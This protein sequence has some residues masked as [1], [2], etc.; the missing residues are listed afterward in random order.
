MDNFISD[1]N[2]K[3]EKEKV[4]HHSKGAEITKEY[5]KYLSN[6]IDLF[7]EQIERQQVGVDRGIQNY[8]KSVNDKKTVASSLAYGS[9]IINNISCEYIDNLKNILGKNYVKN[10]EIKNFLEHKL[11]YKKYNKEGEEKNMSSKL[12]TLDQ[13]AQ[14]TLMT[15][16]NHVDLK[17]KQE[18]GKN[19]EVNLR[20]VANTVVRE[21]ITAMKHK[22]LMLQFGG[23]YR[24]IEETR[25]TNN[26]WKKAQMYNSGIARLLESGAEI[27]IPF[28]ESKLQLKIGHLL[29]GILESMDIIKR[30][31]YNS[32]KKNKKDYITFTDKIKEEI[33]DINKEFRE[34]RPKTVP[35]IIKPKPWVNLVGGGFLNGEVYQEIGYNF[36]Y[37]QNKLVRTNNKEQ[38]KLLYKNNIDEVYD[39]LNSI[40][41]TAWKIN[42]NV[43]NVIKNLWENGVELDKMPNSKKLIPEPMPWNAE[44]DKEILKKW[45]R[46]TTLIHDKNAETISERMTFQF[47][48]E[49]AKECLDYNEIYF[50]YN[51][52]Y[53]GRVYP[54]NPLLNPQG[55]DPVKGMLTF[56]KGLPLGKEKIMLDTDGNVILDE[57]GKPIMKNGL[58]W[59]M[60]HTAN[61]YGNDKGQFDNR[62]K[63]VQD[64][65]ELL[66]SIAENPIDN[67]KLWK[68]TD[69][70]FQF[71]AACIEI[72]GAY[73][74]EN[75]E[76]FI[77][78]LPIAIDGSCSGIQHLSA[79]GRDEVGGAG[80][81]LLDS[82]E[83]NDIYLDVANELI[84][85]LR[86]E[87][88]TQSL[89]WLNSDAINRKLTKRPVMTTPYGVGGFGMFDQVK[90]VLDKLILSEEL[91]DNKNIVYIRDKIDEAIKNI[92]IGARIIMKY[93]QDISR[94]YM[95][96][97]NNTMKWTTPLNFVVVQDY[98]KNELEKRVTTLFGSMKI[99]SRFNTI[100]ENVNIKTQLN[101]ISPNIVHSLD[102]THLMKTVNEV[103][104]SGITDFAVIHD[105]FATHACNTS[106]LKK[107]TTE[108][109][110]DLYEEDLL[111]KISEELIKDLPIKER[112]KLP[113]FPRFGK[114]II[115]DILKSSY[116]F[117]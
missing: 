12:L 71:L 63:W 82:S 6:N 41:N 58:Y 77:S 59:L 2:F 28:I 101:G 25:K 70:P 100:T 22:A 104:K 68:N 67:L 109:F 107:I 110:V 75:T 33:I 72:N 96:S 35:M 16:I 65:L 57:K 14:I 113:E 8:D 32:S 9:I 84:R 27:N 38:Y 18:G 21:I 51:L 17:Q 46:E 19:K 69:N 102:S 49:I 83:P 31:Q 26:N 80:V 62:V 90:E 117:G 4:Y 37:I 116:L 29:V 85:L 64:N 43:Y 7:R 56:S 15:V 53:R 74:C 99:K 39:S 50:P 94:V 98:Y 87:N 36:T 115:K 95:N 112:E 114:L 108:Q 13:I 76:E 48:L 47:K 105:S 91:M 34:L 44:N 79:L 61:V 73:K 88:T 1:D 103:Y 55:D 42:K 111:T 92:I 54:I 106:L 78:Y 3:E 89:L 86:L 40:Q 24:K 20:S 66:K 10:T 45:K 81:N 30:V 97:T 23:Y 52:D 93:F 11:N 60:V 5:N